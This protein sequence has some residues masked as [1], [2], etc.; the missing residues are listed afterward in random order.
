MQIENFKEISVITTAS[1]DIFT[2]PIT[3]RI[4]TYEKKY[5]A[6]MNKKSELSNWIKNVQSKGPPSP[7]NEGNDI[8]I[9]IKLILYNDIR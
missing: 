5:I 7:L 8:N 1:F 4:E 2:E 3:N 6:C 9:K